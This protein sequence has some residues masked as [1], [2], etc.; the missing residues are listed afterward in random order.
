[1]DELESVFEDNKEWERIQDDLERIRGNENPS[2]GEDSQHE[3]LSLDTDTSQ[4][5]R[6]E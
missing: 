3:E 4:Q 2:N 5:L 1:M 6:V